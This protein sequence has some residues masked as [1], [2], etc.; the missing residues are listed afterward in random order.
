MPHRAVFARIQPQNHKQQQAFQQELVNLRRMA[1][2]IARAAKHHGPR[3]GRVGHTAPQLTVDE[4]AHAA[5]GQPGWHAGRHKVHDLQEGP[6]ARTGKPQHGHDDAQQSTMKTHAALPNRQNL[7]RIHQVIQG[8]V[9]QAIAHTP[10]QHH[11]HHAHEQDVFHI[12]PVPGL[13]AFQTDK[14]GVLQAT[15]A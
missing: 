13:L 5:R 9:E 11:A 12:L 3:Q 1:R 4:V 2:Q 7:Q 14:G 15:Q 6:A 8:L 10:T